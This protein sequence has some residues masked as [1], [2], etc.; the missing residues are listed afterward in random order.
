MN[1][2]QTTWLQ[3]RKAF[4]YFLGGELISQKNILVLSPLPVSFVPASTAISFLYG[5]L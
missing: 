2:Q 5:Q 4:Y 1:T 3:S